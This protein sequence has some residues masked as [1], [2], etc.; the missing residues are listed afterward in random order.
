[1]AL[2][3]TCIRGQPIVLQP[4]AKDLLAEL[5]HNRQVSNVTSCGH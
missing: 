5:W 3:A 2:H 1:M 4:L